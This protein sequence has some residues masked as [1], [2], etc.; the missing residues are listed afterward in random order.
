VK[1]WIRVFAE[2]TSDNQWQQNATSGG[3]V[4]R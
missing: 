1:D 2:T 3:L 4:C